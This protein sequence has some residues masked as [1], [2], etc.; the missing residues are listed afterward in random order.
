MLTNLELIR[1]QKLFRKKK[2]YLHFLSIKKK[3]L[4]FD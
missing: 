3:T 2:T 4:G 1:L